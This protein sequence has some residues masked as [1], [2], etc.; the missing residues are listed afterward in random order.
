MKKIIPFMVLLFIC[1][2]GQGQNIL[3]DAQAKA[4]KENKCILLNFSGSDWCVPCIQMQENIFT[5]AVFTT[6]ADSQLVFIRADFPR[7]KKNKPAPETILQNELLAERFNPNGN[8]P[9]SLLM[10]AD[11]AILKAWDGIPEGAAAA[12]V[13]NLRALIEQHKAK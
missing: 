1:Q 10:D 5:K 2:F 8:F 11:G 12:F 4:K 3:K 7:K 9:Y 13:A 6:M